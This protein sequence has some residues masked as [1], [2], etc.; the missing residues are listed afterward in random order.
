M[1]PYMC[2]ICGN[3][4]SSSVEAKNCK[5]LKPKPKPKPNPKPKAKTEA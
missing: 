1:T 5:H 2:T 4:H 3:A